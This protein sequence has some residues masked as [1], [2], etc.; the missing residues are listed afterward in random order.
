MSLM[1]CVLA[2]ALIQLIVISFN[3]VFVVLGSHGTKD[4][5]VNL[6]HIGI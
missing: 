3:L 4:V 6:Y 5:D 2:A 1:L